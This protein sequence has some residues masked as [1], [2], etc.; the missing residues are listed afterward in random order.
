MRIRRERRT[1]RLNPKTEAYKPNAGKKKRARRRFEEQNE[2]RSAFNSPREREEARSQ[3]ERL[4][5]DCKKGIKF[6]EQGI[7]MEELNILGRGKAS[8]FL[9]R[10]KDRLTGEDEKYILEKYK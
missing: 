2:R 8:V 9:E 5:L 3:I 1:K 10:N 6:L 4:G 7:P